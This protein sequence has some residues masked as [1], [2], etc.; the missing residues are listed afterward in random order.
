MNN[1]A[2]LRH[3][4][5]NLSSF[6]TGFSGSLRIDTDF[7]PQG[8][9]ICCDAI[10]LLAD[11]TRRYISPCKSHAKRRPPILSKPLTRFLSTLMGNP[12]GDCVA[13]KEVMCPSP[14]RVMTGFL[15][16]TNIGVPLTPSSCCSM[17]GRTH[18]HHHHR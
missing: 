17:V 3:K 5:E 13:T 15:V 7:A 1:C 16:T 2:F 11:G 12:K 4:P 14:G 6:L 8:D 9:A 18:C 10:A